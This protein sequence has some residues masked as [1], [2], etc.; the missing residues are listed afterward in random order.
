MRRP[1]LSRPTRTPH[2]PDA[3]PN[4]WEGSIAR[5][6]E[7]WPRKPRAFPLFCR[8]A[9][10]LGLAAAVCCSAQLGRLRL[11]AALSPRQSPWGHSTSDPLHRN[12]RL[13]HPLPAA[14]ALG[15]THAERSTRKVAPRASGARAWGSSRRRDHAGRTTATARRRRPAPFA[16]SLAPPPPP[17]VHARANGGPSLLGRAA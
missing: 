9:H 8:V 6:L 14:A 2:R 1:V 10:Q 4:T 13:R 12:R 3:E 7:Y 5:R 17:A 15:S 11:A 16:A